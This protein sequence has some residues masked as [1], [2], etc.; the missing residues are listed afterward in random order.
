MPLSDHL[1]APLAAFLGQRAAERLYWQVV[2]YLSKELSDAEQAKVAASVIGHISDKI[3]I[4]LD[5]EAILADE[6][7]ARDILDV[8]H[9]VLL[10]ALNGSEGLNPGCAAL[11]NEV[12][13]SA[14]SDLVEYHLKPQ[15][16]KRKKAKES[17]RIDYKQRLHLRWEIPESELRNIQFLPM[18]ALA[19]Q[20]SAV[21][22]DDNGR[23]IIS[24]IGEVLG[25][26]NAKSAKGKSFSK[27]S[28]A[29]NPEERAYQ[30]YLKIKSAY[31]ARAEIDPESAEIKGL[32]REFNALRDRMS[33]IQKSL[34]FSNPPGDR[35]NE[36]AEQLDAIMAPFRQA[37]ASDGEVPAPNEYA[38]W[39]LRKEVYKQ[40]EDRIAEIIIALKEK[41]P[42]L[43]DEELLHLSKGNR[44]K[45]RGALLI[46]SKADVADSRVVLTDY[47]GKEDVFLHMLVIRHGL[48]EQEEKKHCSKGII[49]KLGYNFLSYAQIPWPKP[50]PATPVQVADQ[51]D[52]PEAAFSQ[53]WNDALENVAIIGKFAHAAMAVHF[54]QQ[55]LEHQQVITQIMDEICSPI[56]TAD[57]RNHIFMSKI[58]DDLSKISAREKS[59]PQVA[60][61][62]HEAIILRHLEDAKR[63]SQTAL[64]GTASS[65]LQ[66]IE[67]AAKAV[68]AGFRPSC[69][70][71]DTK[72][73][74]PALVDQTHVES[75]VKRLVDMELEGLDETPFIKTEAKA[76]DNEANQQVLKADIKDKLKEAATGLLGSLVYA[77]EYAAVSLDRDLLPKELQVD[78]RLQE[79]YRQ[80]DNDPYIEIRRIGENPAA[81]LDKIG[82]YAKSLSD[83]LGQAWPLLQDQ[84]QISALLKAAKTAGRASVG[85][86]LRKEMEPC[87]QA[88]A[89][90]QQFLLPGQEYPASHAVQLVVSERIPVISR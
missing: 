75:N 54:L 81:A 84:A 71:V 26:A 3:N 1:K 9:K 50:R 90:W 37:R 23:D 64:N 19:E 35:D 34:G 29:S 85:R 38:E 13:I 47:F 18:D 21:F 89:F 66:A 61:I 22:G 44:R 55:A 25:R 60:E 43:S 6:D 76:M 45:H 87:G 7:I 70:I 10:G 67:D 82:A 8:P 48:N 4:G 16:K 56:C 78:Q 41:L 57:R 63:I 31:F 52:R 36:S 28:A 79:L 42:R 77:R 53:A 20:I 12:H 62:N 17:D 46:S 40:S 24:K 58:L 33:L 73:Q 74:R 49:D 11:I 69:D 80:P 15:Y 72:S 39:N 65:V 68:R 59:A 27:A 88:A 51:D 2:K 30:S 5:Q 83:T 32:I 14:A 86:V